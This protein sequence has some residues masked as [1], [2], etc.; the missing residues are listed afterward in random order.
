MVAF[1]ILYALMIQVLNCCSFS[2]TQ[3]FSPSPFVYHHV[4]HDCIDVNKIYYM[5]SMRSN[6]LLRNFTL[7]IS[8][9]KK[10][11]QSEKYWL[12]RIEKFSKCSK[13]LENGRFYY[14]LIR[15]CN[16]QILPTI[17]IVCSNCLHQLV[18]WKYQSIVRERVK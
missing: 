5:A 14:I 18:L 7:R 13:T 17:P 15:I 11:L 3:C 6:L 1:D 4:H 16:K 10:H 8:D 9:L 12:K 2:Q